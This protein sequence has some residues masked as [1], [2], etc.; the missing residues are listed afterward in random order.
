MD[1]ELFKACQSYAETTNL[2]VFVIV[3]PEQKRIGN[4]TTRSEISQIQTQSVFV[5][6]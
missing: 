3:I 2:D 1:T 4:S 5:D 6:L